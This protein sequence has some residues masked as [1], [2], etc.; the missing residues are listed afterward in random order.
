M[1]A[2]GPK[3]FEKLGR[4]AGMGPAELAHRT[5][6]RARCAGER[7]ARRA[8]T[9]GAGALP[10]ETEAAFLARLPVL[11]AGG[12]PGAPPSFLRYLRRHVAPRFYP[13][14][15]PV[16]RSAVARRLA[17]GA[18]GWRQELAAEAERL[19]AHRV[20]VLGYGEVRCGGAIDWHLDWHL[21][22]H[23]DPVTGERW[24]RRYW[25]DYDP[26][27]DRRLPDPKRVLE[28]N[29]HQHL[30]RLARAAY[31]LGDDR[32]AREAVEQMLS[33]ID[34]NPPG[35]GVHW[36]SSLEIALRAMS[37]L[38]TLVLIL[39]SGVLTEAA[40]RRIG[41]SLFAQL[42]H[43]RRYPSV[44]TS[45]NTHLLGEATGLFVGGVLF[46]DA[47]GGRR[48]LSRGAE[49]L[50]GGTER[51]VS[52]DGVHWE[53][54]TSYH[55]YALELAL[56]ALVLARE[57]R[58][59]LP[60]RFRD[61]V[62]AMA[63]FLRHVARPDGTLPL[64]GDD[65]GGR[66]FALAGSSYRDVSGLLAV[67]AGVFG[68]ADLLV[69]GA[70]PA[71]GE[72][73]TW[74]LGPEGW[75]VLDRLEPAVP[76]DGPETGQ[77]SFRDSAGGAYVV[78][79]A[80]WR[81]DDPHLVF[82]A[83]GMGRPSGGHGHADALAVTLS[84]GGRELLVDPG[85]YL[86][87]GRP[88][89]RDAFRSTGA[90]NTAVVDGRDQSEPAG[91]FRWRRE[92]PVRFL[93]VGSSEG[94]DWAAA[95]H[96]GYRSLAGGGVVHRRRLVWVRPAYWLLF[97]EFLGEGEHTFELLF[98]LPPDA[99]LTA[100]AGSGA[101]EARLEGLSGPAG[102]ELFVHATA[103]VATR[104]LRGGTAP[105]PS[106]PEARGGWVSHRYGEKRPA[107]VVSARFRAAAPAAAVSVLVPRAA[108]RLQDLP[109]R[110]SDPR[111]RAVPVTAAAGGRAPGALAV[112]VDH[113]GG[114]DLAILT[115]RASKVPDRRPVEAGPVRALGG[116]FWVRLDRSPEGPPA[117]PVPVRL[118]AFDGGR[119]EL[120]TPVPPLAAASARRSPA[121]R[122]PPLT[123]LRPGSPTESIHVRNRWSL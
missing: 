66:A 51:Q 49:L 57:N 3:I 58:V 59:P 7:A 79:R 96:D 27:A 36:S 108:R 101:R 40:V 16:Y 11:P 103:P 1:D 71:A 53:L 56:Q 88:G 47:R 44:Y 52:R 43:V 33:W 50:A 119:L 35:V 114:E 73:A 65:D 19:C 18:P 104:V 14:A 98:H 26:V 113:A 92:A 41:R 122:R 93:G 10:G 20:E 15:A 62:E 6:E 21:D 69:P 118:L 117:A 24:E 45:P 116:A 64:L 5:R 111:P 23:R 13:A 89:W 39:P 97:D 80:G 42:E 95:E 94:V 102:L 22:W 8:G 29:R 115:P 30:P 68:R 54:S 28:L 99:E 83:A 120:R 84:A 61:R 85:T 90:H 77:A 31:L 63:V 38:W 91:T 100:P 55:A 17:R 107:P 109:E 25:A 32:Y 74:L 60:R 76:E 86:Y 123:A 82:D 46:S 81:R 70:A 34:Q 9:G 105:E 4:L 2:T 87:N 37:W 78:Q 72:G 12:A 106:A 75:D 110:T 112:S 67:A 48:W 121:R